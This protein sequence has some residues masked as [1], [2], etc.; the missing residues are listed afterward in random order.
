MESVAT[1]LTSGASPL[2]L[3]GERAGGVVD[4]KIFAVETEEEDERGKDRDQGRVADLGDA[5][6]ADDEEDKGS[7]EERRCGGDEQPLGGGDEGLVLHVL[8]SEDE[9]EDHD[10][11]ESGVGP[12]EPFWQ[13]LAA[14]AVEVVG[15]EDGEGRDGGQDVA[16]EL[17]SREGEEDD[18]EEGPED[19]ELGEGV[20]GAGVAEVTLGVVADLPL[21]DGDFDGVDQGA[22]GDDG[23]GHEADE[24]DDYVVPEGLVVLV[25][26]G[27]EA[28]E[29]VFEEEE[30]VR[31]SGCASGRRCTRAAP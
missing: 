31:R 30:T 12:E 15:G 23:P 27:G 1:S 25:A 9:H 18:G 10:G 11:T 4:V 21:G 28:L 17:G 19:E 14:D 6:A 26:V 13:A 24:Q 20:A 7:E 3:A 29:I 5:P 22:D 2:D 8:G 16:G